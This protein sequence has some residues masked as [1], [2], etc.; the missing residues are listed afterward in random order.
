M[1]DSKA[2]SA[3]NCLK[4]LQEFVK[5]KFFLTKQDPGCVE[6]LALHKTKNKN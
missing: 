6:K 1:I 3:C 5:K 4:C 2:L